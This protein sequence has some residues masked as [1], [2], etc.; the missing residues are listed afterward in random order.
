M[1]HVSVQALMTVDFN[2]IYHFLKLQ[3]LSNMFA[4]GEQKRDK[5]CRV[6]DYL[7]I[8]L[9]EVP[10]YFL[11]SCMINSSQTLHLQSIVVK[12]YIRFKD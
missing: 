8:S 3:G 9:F 1:H 6:E 5:D 12:F 7:S 2:A 10:I 11:L 4:S